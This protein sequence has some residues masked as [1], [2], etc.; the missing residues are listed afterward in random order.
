MKKCCFKLS[1]LR[2]IRKAG[3]ADNWSERDPSV[4]G[5]ISQDKT[6][7]SGLVSKDDER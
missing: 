5:T 3:A 7:F 6:A 2:E 1:D 4:Y